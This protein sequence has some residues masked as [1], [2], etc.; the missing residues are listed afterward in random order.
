[1]FFVN[2]SYPIDNFFISTHPDDV[3]NK[4]KS[5][6]YHFLPT[7]I[8]RNIEKLNIYNLDNQ[9]HDVFF[10]MSHGVNRG[11]IKSGKIDEREKFLKI[12]IEMNKNIK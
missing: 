7:P 10:A 5:V 12:L 1:M 2:R 8:D 4:F 9:T 3:S 11:T 6:D